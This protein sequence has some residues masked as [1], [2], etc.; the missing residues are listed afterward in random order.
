VSGDPNGGAPA[1]SLPKKRVL[2]I[3]LGNACRSPMAESIA[4]RDATDIIECSSAGI[5]P[6]GFVPELT[7]NTLTANGCSIDRLES[8]PITREEWDAADI[9]INMSGI[10]RYKAFP[11]PEK[12]EDWAV[13][14][15][16]GADPAVYQTIYEDIRERIGKL[17]ER[18][19]KSAK[20]TSGKQPVKQP[21]E[22]SRN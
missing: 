6:L 3:C 15:P 5:I 10:D 22:G 2:F 18:L 11:E 19:R 12:V 14:D 1:N 17:A 8:T 4:R 21:A 16:Y 9:V 20:A 13:Q 7:Q